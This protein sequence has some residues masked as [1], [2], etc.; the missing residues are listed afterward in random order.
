LH[1]SEAQWECS[2]CQN[3]WKLEWRPL[4]S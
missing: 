3:F 2:F 1:L 4:A